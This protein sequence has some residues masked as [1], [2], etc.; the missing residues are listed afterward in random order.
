MTGAL[1]LAGARMPTM[2]LTMEAFGQ[3]RRQD[4]PGSLANTI[5]A[6]TRARSS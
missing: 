4:R 6:V 5:L 3:G 2:R 1:D